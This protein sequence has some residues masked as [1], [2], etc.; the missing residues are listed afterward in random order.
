MSTPDQQ[1]ELD[2][3]CGL[4]SIV[5]AVGDLWPE[6][7]DRA[8]RDELANHICASIGDKATASMRRD[9][10][11][12]LLMQRM[13]VAAVHFSKRRLRDR[14]AYSAPFMHERG[15]KRYE[16]WWDDL[17]GY[18]GGSLAS[19]I[20]GL[21]RPYQHW[22]VI[23]EINANRAVLRDSGGEKEIRFAELGFT[24]SGKEHEVD[25]RQVFV[26]ERVE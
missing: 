5:N 3:F 18:A 11:S 24:G 4:Y 25:W 15:V 10:A 8:R 9:G 2:G 16:H 14:L 6:S 1:G 13:L 21:S 17:A 7:M 12:I 22:T 26:L 20:I 19:A 23:S